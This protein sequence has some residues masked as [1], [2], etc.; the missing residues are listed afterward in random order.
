[1]K[2]IYEYFEYWTKYIK[3]KNMKTKAKHKIKINF[4]P[5]VYT[6]KDSPSCLDS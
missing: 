2:D 3:H 1:M 4:N 6:F 5:I